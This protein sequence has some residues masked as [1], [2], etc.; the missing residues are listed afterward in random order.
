MTPEEPATTDPALRL[1][2]LI[3]FDE[4]EEEEVLDEGDKA[5]DEQPSSGDEDTRPE[6]EAATDELAVDPEADEPLVGPVGLGVPALLRDDEEEEEEDVG[7][8]MELLLRA[9]L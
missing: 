6:D 9:F 1:H 3:W 7:D 4:L 5:E 2:D 8:K